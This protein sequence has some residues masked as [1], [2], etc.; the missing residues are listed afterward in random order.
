MFEDGY[1][2]ALKKKNV[3]PVWGALTGFTESGIIID[4]EQVIDADV[5]VLSTGFD[6]EV[7]YK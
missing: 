3:T 4:N 1:F 2:T 7:S 5:V 6:L